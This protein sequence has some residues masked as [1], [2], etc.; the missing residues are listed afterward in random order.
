MKLRLADRSYGKK[1]EDM[2]RKMT[3][4]LKERSYGLK[5]EAMVMKNE[6]MIK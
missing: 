3:F 2:D 4:R 5:N 1:N 6:V